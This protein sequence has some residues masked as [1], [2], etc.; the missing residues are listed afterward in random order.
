MICTPLLTLRDVG[1]GHGTSVCKFWKIRLSE[2]CQFMANSVDFYSVLHHSDG[3]TQIM[4]LHI[5]LKTHCDTAY[6]KHWCWVGKVE[7]KQCM[8]VCWKAL[9]HH[10]DNWP[11]IQAFQM[12][13]P[14]MPLFVCL[15]CT[16]KQRTR[17]MCVHARYCPI[18]GQRDIARSTNCVISMN[19]MWHT[20]RSALTDE[21]IH[22]AQNCKM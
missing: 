7:I 3:D 8:L 2:L 20:L 21:P 9:R 12:T 17:E 14:G 15:V 1:R 4:L 19:P 6:P 13:V 11:C 16:S 10:V 18:S 22:I 5:V